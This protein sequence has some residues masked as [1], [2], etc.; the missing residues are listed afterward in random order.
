MSITEPTV[1][2]DPRS[3]PE[4]PVARPPGIA[5]ADGPDTVRRFLEVRS[6]TDALAERLSP[7][8]QTPQ[9][10]TEASPAKWHRAHVTWFFEEFILRRNPDYV[11]YDETFRYLFNSYYETVGERHPRPDRGLVTR[12]GVRDVTRYREHV[13]AAMVEAL[14]AGRFD[15]AALELLELGC[16][17]EQQHQELLLMDI[18]HLFSTHAFGPVYVDRDPDVP[19]RSAPLGWREFSGGVHEIGAVG[20]GFSYDNEGPRHRVH[21]ED[22]AVSD[23]LVTN[24]DWLEF[25]ADDGYRRHEYWLSDGWAKIH[26][27]GWQ[28]PSY[29]REEDGRW[30]TFTLSGRRP[31]V[32]DEPV[33][34]VSFYEA[35]AYARWAGARLPTEFEWEVAAGT[36]GDARGGLLDPGRCHPGR[37]G[38][39]MVGDVW[40]WTASAY[41]PYPGFV[42][43]N[44]AVGEYNGKFMSDQHV[45]RGASAVTPPGHERITYRNFF[46]AASR[47]VFS[48]LRLAR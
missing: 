9:S 34:H 3:D 42:P 47:W 30:T 4:S 27:T 8:D 35:D 39:A 12:P 31:V 15:D 40:E 38:S 5:T 16:N 13:D 46:P 2:P 44:G 28:A 1:R 26:E 36:L 45:L 32:P 18:K 43:A 17:H 6:L 22:F 33:T 41:L 10:M 11:V 19:G 25:M 29:W 24:A 21:L 37:A 23:R 48:G 14:E 20:S 7:E